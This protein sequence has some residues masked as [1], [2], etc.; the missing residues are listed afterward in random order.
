MIGLPTTPVLQWVFTILVESV[1]ENEP[2]NAVS[3][4]IKI[5]AGGLTVVIKIVSD[6]LPQRFVTVAQYLP[7]LLI[8]ICF[9][10]APVF[11]WAVGL[12]AVNCKMALVQMVVSFPNENGIGK[13]STFK[14]IESRLLQV[15]AVL[16]NQYQPCVLVVMVGVIAPVFHI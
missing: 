8:M 12:L 15:L 16:C 10:V 4:P 14:N 7:A 3:S 2:Q 9:A 1:F 6:T 11:Q 5:G 13:E